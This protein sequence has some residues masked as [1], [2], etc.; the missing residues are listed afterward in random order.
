[1]ESHG[2]QN[3]IWEYEESK[4]VCCGWSLMSNDIEMVISQ[5]KKVLKSDHLGLL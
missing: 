1:M 4:E 2:G 5:V 3:K